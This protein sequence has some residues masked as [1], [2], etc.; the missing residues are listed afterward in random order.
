M[1]HGWSVKKLQALGALKEHISFFR[2]RGN[3]Q[4]HRFAVH[5]Y[6]EEIVGHLRCIDGSSDPLEYEKETRKIV[7]EARGYVIRY[8]LAGAFNLKRD[9]ETLE[10][11]FPRLMR[12]FRK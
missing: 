2:K 5:R 4:L 3:L 7:R 12:F 10:R 8:W 1:N 9:R 11:L 6:V